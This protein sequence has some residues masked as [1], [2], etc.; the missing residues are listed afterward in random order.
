[1]ATDK[2]Q[3][4]YVKKYQNKMYRIPVYIPAEAREGLEAHA[5]ARGYDSINA[6]T[7]ALYEADGALQANK[8]GAGE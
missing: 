3:I 7:K 4:E 6:Y 5:K 8:K 2:R 1:M